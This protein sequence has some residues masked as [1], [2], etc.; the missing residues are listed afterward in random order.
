MDTRQSSEKLSALV[1]KGAEA[2]GA[3]VLDMGLSTTPQ[4][5]SL[6]PSALHLA[7]CTLNFEPSALH[8]APCTLNFESSAL[9]LA[10]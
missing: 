5:G 7:P 9:H 10:P 1:K 3:K 8:L 2:A 4:V 6:E